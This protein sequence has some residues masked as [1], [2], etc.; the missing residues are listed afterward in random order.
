MGGLDFLLHSNYHLNRLPDIPPFSKELLQWF[1]DI[2][3]NPRKGES[4]LWNNKKILIDSVS[5]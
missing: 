1:A 3:E 2:F 5:L 4:I